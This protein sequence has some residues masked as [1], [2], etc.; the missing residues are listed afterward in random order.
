MSS[1]CFKPPGI[2]AGPDDFDRV[3]KAITA[4]GLLQDL[5]VFVR[6]LADHELA[7][8]VVTRQMEGR[9]L[10]HISREV[11][12]RVI[13]CGLMYQLGGDEKY[14]RR[15]ILDLQAAARF[16]DWNPSH[17]LDVGEMCTAFAL[18]LGWLDNAL[19]DSERSGLE[20]ALVTL[21]L[22]VGSND[23]N[24]WYTIATNNWNA[25]CN[26]GL[27]MGAIAVRHRYPEIAGKLIARCISQLP[28]HGENY[29]PEGAFVEGSTYWAY[30]TAFH[31]LAVESLLRATGSTHG[32]DTLPGFRES[33]AYMMHMVGPSGE[34]YPYFDSRALRIPLPA[35]FWFGRH[36]DDPAATRTEAEFVRSVIQG[37]LEPVLWTENRFFALSLL[38]MEPAHLENDTPPPLAW[39]GN[40]PNPVAFWRE[41]WASDALW[42]GA[43]G[44]RATLSHGHVDSGSFIIEAGGVRWAHDLGMEE[45]H[46]LEAMGVKL[47]GED[48]WKIFRLGPES[49]S[50]PRIGD[51]APDPD[52]NCP[53]IHWAVTP[54]PAVTFDLSA[55]YPKTVRRLHRTVAS[56][57]PGVVRI[58]DDVEGLSSGAV[59]RFTWITAA[60][61]VI[62]PSGVVLRESGRE[63]RI[64][65]SLASASFTTRVLDAARL[66]TPI[67]TPMPALKRVEFVVVSKGAGFS[68]EITGAL[69]R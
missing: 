68:F 35:L 3:R 66:L 37:Q 29:A 52:G 34:F 15:A 2:I 48:R 39:S 25:V 20:D 42:V 55:L 33:A 26:G 69:V 23:T 18:G 12:R 45:Y 64:T 54:H 17:F 21:G 65:V 44:G 61:V 22:E 58:L 1:R 24:P 9:R 10:L 5:A 49:H 11:L 28:L 46:R 50:L 60:E 67:D 43:K 6:R 59:Y 51:V 41:S 13:H 56:A 7:Q 30:G 31:A 32:L 19:S 4:P 14:A 62:E 47:W 63:F 53:R 38:W 27:A 16:S 40:G 36:F 57:G 8:P